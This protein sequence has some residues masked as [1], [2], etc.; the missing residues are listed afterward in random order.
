MPKKTETKQAKKSAPLTDADRHKRFLDMA[1][2][3][4]ASDSA[5]DFT[6]AFAQVAKHQSPIEKGMAA[7]KRSASAQIAL[8]DKAQKR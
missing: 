1:K 7:P 4:G 6:R 2:E 8:N 5:E 3:V